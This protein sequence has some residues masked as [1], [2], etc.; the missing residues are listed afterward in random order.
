MIDWNGKPTKWA[1]WN[2]E[3]VNARPENVG[4]RKITSSNIVA[5]LQTAYHFTGKKKYK[6][7]ILMLM[8]DHGY[9]KNLMRPMKDI[10]MAP[11]NADE[12]SKE[13][14]TEWNHSDDE[15]YFCGYWG[16]YRYALNDTLKA[17]YKAAII[18]H[19]EYERPEKEGLW[20]IMTAI[21]GAKNIDLNEAVWYLQEYPL[22]LINWTV[23]NS[24]RKDITPVKPNFRGQTI[25]EVLPPDETRICR[26]NSNLFE[27]DGHD[28]G[29]SENSAG[30]IWLLPYWIGRYLGVISEPVMKK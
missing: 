26:H 20:D 30:D 28:A 24:Q 12:L 29:R 15:M 8:K 9:L 25:T 14:S 17:K 11:A 27:L 2:P 23:K 21:S 16:L 10:G 18:D 5:M 6:D 4:D 19:F 7:A 13:L 3:Y 22:D 1:R